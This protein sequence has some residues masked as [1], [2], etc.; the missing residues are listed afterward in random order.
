VKRKERFEGAAGC[1]CQAGGVLETEPCLI[2]PEK[3]HYS[4]TGGWSAAWQTLLLM[5]IFTVIKEMM[6]HQTVMEHGD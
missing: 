5:C 3:Q 2:Q 4:R 1:V 6:N